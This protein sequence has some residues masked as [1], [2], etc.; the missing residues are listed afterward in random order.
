MI[1][2][3]LEISVVSIILLLGS[4]VFTVFFGIQSFYGIVRGRI[5]SRYGYVYRKS[6]PIWFY[7]H[8][9]IYVLL[10]VYPVVFAILY[11]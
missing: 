4:V 5:L 3:E 6:A 11:L 7:L 2:L 1:V 8:L 10:A 9:I